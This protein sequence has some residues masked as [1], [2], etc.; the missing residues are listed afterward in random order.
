[1]TRRRAIAAWL[2]GFALAMVACTFTIGTPPPSPDPSPSPVPMGP[3]SAAAAMSALC[4]VPKT[5]SGSG[6]TPEGPTAPA[7]ATVEQQVEKVRGLRYTSH[8]AVTPLTQEQIDRRLQKNFDKSYPVDFYDRRSQAWGTIGVIPAGASLREALLAFRTGQVVGFYNP[9]NQQLVYIGDT[10]LDQ[11]ER[12]ILAHELTHALDDQHF[13]LKRLDAIGARCDDEVFT[14]GL[15]AIEGSAQY[16]AT[17]VLMRFPSDAPLGGGGDGGSLDDVPPFI[18]ALELWPYEAGIAFIRHL[19]EAGGTAQ[20]DGALTTFPVS[21]EQIMHPERWPNDT[22]QPVDVPDLAAALGA[23]WHDLD[24]MTV[25]E[26]WLQ[27]ML[28]LRLDDGV[29]EAAAAG[30]DGGLYRAWT[31]GTHT[32]VVLRTVWDS[33][34]DAQEFSDAMEAWMGDATSVSLEDA[35]VDVGFASDAATLSALRA[36]LQ[37]SE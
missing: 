7:I 30:W 32:A 15:G 16:F 2:A 33:T 20:V 28:A 14:A 4:D 22:P 8:V 21:T 5:G 9:A 1:M 37:A 23:D 17:Q 13:G 6:V 24:V 34:D 18:T 12:F 27:L 10:D 11:T 26:A 25:G 36:A 35:R 29:A 19:D 3:G 31:D